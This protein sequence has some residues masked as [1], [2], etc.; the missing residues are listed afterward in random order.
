[1]YVTASLSTPV[2]IAFL[3]QQVLEN[4]AEFPAHLL[5]CLSIN[6]LSP[7][8][9]EFYKSFI[10]EQRRELCKMQPSPPSE[11]EL[12][13]KWSQYWQAT[14]L[15][16][17]T[18]DVKLLQTNAVSHLL[19]WTLRTFP[20]ASMMLMDPLD[21][22]SQGHLRAWT[23]IMSCHRATC[24]GSS[25]IS[26]GSHAFQTLQNALT[27]LDDGVRLAALNVLCCSPKST[28]MPSALEFSALRNF[29]PLNLNSEAPA[30]RQQLYSAVKKF[31]CRVRDTCLAKVLKSKS[32][33]GLALEDKN[34]LCKGVGESR[35]L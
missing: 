28:E 32:K 10:Q 25:W 13:S 31:L 30:F 6:H 14:L 1:M 22:T 16:A 29:I 8:A 7:W 23:C 3:F 27:S 11:F 34:I 19:P 2:K 24:G 15:E 26:E 18:S 12:A 33:M 5:K 35:C 17:L 21:P 20:S 4:Y 9:C